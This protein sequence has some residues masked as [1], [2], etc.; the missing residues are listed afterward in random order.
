MDIV[1]KLA[2][3]A[4]IP[5]F[6]TCS[7]P[8]TI[9]FILVFL[10]KPLKEVIKN[11]GKL[12]FQAGTAGITGTVE[13]E[14]LEA[15]INLGAAKTAL[16]DT[17]EGDEGQHLRGVLEEKEVR[18]IANVVNRE[19]TPESIRK[20]QGASVLWVDDIPKNNEY[21]VRAFE[22]LGIQCTSSLTTEDALEKASKQKYDVII[23]DMS[24]YG[25][26]RAGFELFDELQRRKINTPF[27]LHSRLKIEK[28]EEARSKGIKSISDPDKLLQA[29]VKAIQDKKD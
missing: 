8:L 4:I 29:V 6:Q 27:I 16:T 2:K 17:S 28:R 3:D 20:L 19:I 1:D 14:R 26:S 12:T 23:S 25:N 21:K 18:D 10:G 24:R 15:A 11:I 7:W 9:A 13:I 5:L 22:V